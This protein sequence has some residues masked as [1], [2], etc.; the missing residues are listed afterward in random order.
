MVESTGINTKV[1]QREKG[2]CRRKYTTKN[3]G[4]MRQTKKSISN[5]VRYQKAAQRTK[6][7]RFVSPNKEGRLPKAVAS[8]NERVERRSVARTRRS[9]N[10]E[11]D[12]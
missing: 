3:K 9:V 11:R 5:K 7:N 2:L 10:A 8:L 1:L 4:N 6:R 12:D